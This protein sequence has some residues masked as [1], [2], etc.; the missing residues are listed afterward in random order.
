KLFSKP[1]AK[2]KHL[3]MW[4]TFLQSMGF[5]TVALVFALY[6]STAARTGDI[7]TTLVTATL[8]VSVY[9]TPAAPAG[10]I[11]TPLDTATMSVVLAMWVGIRFVPRLASDV[12]W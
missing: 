8:C 1:L 9:S 5:L 2:D 4:K 10:D 7:P 12:D 6:S 3:P 11:P